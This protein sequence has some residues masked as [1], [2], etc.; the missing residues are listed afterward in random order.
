L[1]YIRFEN[2]PTPIFARRWLDVEFRVQH[3]GPPDP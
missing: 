1:I 2:L 3:C